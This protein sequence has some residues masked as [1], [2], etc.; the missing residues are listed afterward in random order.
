MNKKGLHDYLECYKFIEDLSGKSIINMVKTVEMMRCVYDSLFEKYGISEPK[1]SVMLL[2]YTEADGMPL[3][4]IGEKMLVS[5]ANMTGLIDRMERENLVE[6]CLNPKDKR[7]TIARLTEKGHALFNSV[8]DDH[9][10]FSRQMTRA[11]NTQEKESLN[12][13][14]EKLQGDIVSCFGEGE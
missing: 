10:A 5:R 8:K 9:I 3:S 14:L 1:F 12:G 11:L 7:S 13:L 6:K 4:D 2:L